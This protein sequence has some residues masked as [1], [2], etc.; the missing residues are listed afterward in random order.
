MEIKQLS[1]FVENKTGSLNQVCRILAENNINI[2]TLSL[3]DTEQFGVL[4]LLVKDWPAAKTALE[5]AGL[6]VRVTDVLAL[7]VDDKVGGLQNVLAVLD[8]NELSVE[9]M[10]AFT[11]GSGNRAI[12][13]FRFEDTDRAVKCLAAEHFD[14]VEPVEIFH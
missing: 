4:R 13:V 6:V 7:P 8:R 5:K 12:M 14:V 2:R 9:Y 10:Y 3:A 1:L 11:F